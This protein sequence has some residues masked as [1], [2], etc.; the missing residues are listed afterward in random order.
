MSEARAD[1]QP[2]RQ[3][4]R[5]RRRRQV[6]GRPRRGPDAPGARGRDRRRGRGAGVGD[7]PQAGAPVRVELAEDSS[8]GF[9]PGRAA[10]RP[11]REAL[12]ECVCYCT[13]IQRLQTIAAPPG[14]R[15]WTCPSKPSTPRRPRPC[16]PR[17]RRSRSSSARARSCG[18][19]RARSSTTSRSSR[20]ARSAS[21]SRSA[22]AACRAAASS[23][24]TARSRRGKTTLTLHVVAE[25][26]KR[27]GVVRLHRRR[28]RARRQLRAEARRQDRGAAHLPAR[29]RRAGARD[30]RHARALGRGRRDRHRLGRGARAQGR[31]RRRDGRLARRP[32]GAPDEPG[33]AQAHRHDLAVATRWSSSSTRS[34]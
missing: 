31:D 11:R 9:P 5:H 33:A 32:A 6:G 22:S 23:R 14:D 10:S 7:R 30:R 34:A 29:Q 18:S 8:I 2:D 3:R 27:G 15:P 17:S 28:A 4:R 20:P 19:A 21:T 25:V 12:R 13:N 1:H 26:Q 24:S 16:R